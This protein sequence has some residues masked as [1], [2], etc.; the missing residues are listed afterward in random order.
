MGVYRRKKS[1]VWWMSFTVNG[2]QYQRSTNTT[3]RRLAEKILG[4]ITTEVMEEKW[5]DRDAARRH[6]YDEMKDRFIEEHVPT[7]SAGMQRSYIVSFKHLDGFFSGLTLDKLSADL[8]SQ[9]VTYRRKAK[10]QVGPSSRN[11]EVAALSKM[12]NCARRWQWVRENPCQLVPK[13]KEPK[14]VGRALTAEEEVLLLKNAKGLCNGDLQ[15]IILLVLHTGF[16]IG[17]L[18]LLKWTDIDLSKKTIKSLNEKTRQTYFI[19]MSEALH[20]MLLKRSRVCHISGLVFPSDSGTPLDRNNIRRAFK[21]ARE[22]SK[23]RNFRFHDLRHTAATRLAQAG[24]DIYAIASFLNH[25]QLSTTKRYA[26][27]SIESLR[28]AVRALDQKD[29]TNG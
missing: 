26:K 24:V 15:D 14:D 9:Y 27:H 1:A 22:E 20:V 5:F 11:R 13:E 17:Q 7:V 28:K 19:P 12:L 29:G 25:S 23:I 10:K 16:R 8:I 3:D 6:T 4:K 21:I 2:T 18:P